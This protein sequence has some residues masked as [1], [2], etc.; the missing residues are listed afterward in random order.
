MISNE[1]ALRFIL[2]AEKT[3]GLII[4]ALALTLPDGSV[5]SYPATS[6]IAGCQKVEDQ[7]VRDKGP[8]PAFGKH[9]NY[10]LVKCLPRISRN[11]GGLVFDIK[12]E[13]VI[14]PDGAGR[15]SSLRIHFDEN[16]PGTQ[17]C[18]GI[19]H[20]IHWADFVKRMIIL[21]QEHSGIDLNVYYS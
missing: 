1:P 12:P 8:I 15:R 10:Y 4:G 5:I 9:E 3:R 2:P 13:K 17:G 7:W 11:V 20:L 19:I 16:Q 6:G 18:I 14:E 21:E